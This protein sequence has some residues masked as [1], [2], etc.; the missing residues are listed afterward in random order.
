MM[1]DEQTLDSWIDALERLRALPREKLREP[2]LSLVLAW[3]RELARGEGEAKG[4]GVAAVVG[5]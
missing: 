1:I 2:D 4:I 3:E 5:K